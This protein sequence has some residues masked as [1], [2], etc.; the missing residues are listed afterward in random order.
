MTDLSDQEKRSVMAVSVAEYNEWMSKAEKNGWKLPGNSP[1]PPH[2]WVHYWKCCDMYAR[3]F[4][5]G[6][7]VAPHR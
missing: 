5:K 6:R 1:L 7:P 3:G 2:S 4:S